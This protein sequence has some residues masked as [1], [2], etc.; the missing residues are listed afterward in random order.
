L[1]AV[2]IYT[3]SGDG[4]ETSLFGGERVPKDHYRVA[5]YGDVDELNSSIG[6]AVAAEPANLEHDLLTGVQ[7][8]LFSLGAQ[9]AT[10]NREKVAKA[11]ERTVVAEARVGELEGA[12]DRIQ[13]ELPELS[14]FIL[15]GG[16]PKSAWLHHARSVCRRAERSIVALARAEEVPAIA[17]V[18]LN[19]LSDLLFV[20]ARLANDRAGVPDTKW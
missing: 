13:D 8:D 15:P 5:A 18:Y 6:A 2:R 16:T 1:A 12:I 14:S 9:L 11:L 7:R 4:G 10:P 20:L 3:K 19:R 17:L